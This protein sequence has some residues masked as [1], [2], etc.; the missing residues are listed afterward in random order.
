MREAV[1]V[2]TVH[3][4]ADVHGVHAAEGLSRWTC[5]ARRAGLHGGWEAVEWAWLPPGGVSGEHR[6]TR[7]EELYHVLTGRGELTLDGRPCPVRPGTT[8]LTA[9]GSRHGLRNTGEEPLSWLVV[10]LPAPHA[11]KDPTQRPTKD[12]VMHPTGPSRSTVVPDLHQ[13]GPVDASTVLTGPLRTV[14]VT[15]L[16]PA[17]TA[18]LTARGVE[19]TLYVTEGTGTARTASARVPLAAGVALTLPLGT[20]AELRAGTHGLEYF[21]AVLAVPTEEQR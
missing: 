10:E 13:A 4:P 5:L 2:A 18:A 9:A 14:R 15:R 6:H 3:E 19:H 11:T 21:H 16:L 17:G 20:H 7:T 12:T 1:V 8:V